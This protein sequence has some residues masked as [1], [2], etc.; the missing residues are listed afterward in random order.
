VTMGDVLETLPFGN[1][2]ATFQLE[3]TYVKAA[4][5]NGASRYPSANGGFAQVAGLRYTINADQPAG[6]RVSDIEVWNGTT[7]EPLVLTQI[8]NAVTNDFMRK[9]GDNYLMFRD[10]AINPYD[11]GPA[12]DEALADYFRTYS[13]VTPVIEGRITIAP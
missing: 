2:I 8:Y 9:G 4:L 6:S 3:G 13:P 10:Y 11:F 7:W 1:A 5:E 12:L